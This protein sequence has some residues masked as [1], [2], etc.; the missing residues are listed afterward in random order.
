[1]RWPSVC[2]VSVV[3]NWPTVV[4]GFSRWEHN[5]QH[6]VGYSSNARPWMSDGKWPT[7]HHPWL[8]R[9]PT[10]HVDA[11]QFWSPRLLLGFYYNLASLVSLIANLVYSLINSSLLT[12]VLVLQI[13]CTN[14]FISFCFA[15]VS[16]SWLI[17]SKVSLSWV[18]LCH[19]M[20]ISEVSWRWP[21][22]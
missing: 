21:S 1:M 16:L 9:F 14:F 3:L 4:R 6:P 13:F 7:V 10:V 12:Q 22:G 2:H 15:F 5:G 20:T 18:D 19:L 8:F 17:I 11:Q